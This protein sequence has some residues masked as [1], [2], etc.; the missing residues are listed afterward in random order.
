VTVGREPITY[1]GI[2]SIGLRRRGYTNEQ[3]NNVQDIYRLI[4]NSGLNTT[5]A[6][7]KIES[8]FQ[9][10]VERDEILLFVRNSARGI[11]K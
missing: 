10:T 1:A 3:I 9:A 7:A 2:N 8:E 11:I 4:Y 5:D 6:I